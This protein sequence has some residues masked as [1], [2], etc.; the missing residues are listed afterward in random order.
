MLLYIYIFLKCVLGGQVVHSYGRLILHESVISDRE[1]LQRPNRSRGGGKIECRVS[2]GNASFTYHGLNDTITGYKMVKPGE[3]HSESK[4]KVSVDIVPKALRH[5]N[6]FAIEGHCA[7]IYHYL[8][9]RKG[10]HYNNF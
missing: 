2:S 8:F 9:L 10:K 6:K 5:P 3:D 1:Q 7:G 4:N